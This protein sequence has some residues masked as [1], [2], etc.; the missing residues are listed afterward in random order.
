MEERKIRNQYLKIRISREEMETLKTDPN[1]SSK[2]TISANAK[3]YTFLNKILNDY[4]KLKKAQDDARN[5]Y[6]DPEKN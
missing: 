2:Q 1:D 5:I 3:Y 4:N 6:A